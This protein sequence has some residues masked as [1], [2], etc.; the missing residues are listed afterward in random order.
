MLV[1][2]CWY[3]WLS[4]QPQWL[5][6]GWK[7]ASRPPGRLVDRQVFLRATFS[8]CVALGAESWDVAK[9]D[10]KPFTRVGNGSRRP[11]STE[12]YLIWPCHKEIRCGE[13]GPRRKNWAVSR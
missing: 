3:G 6:V 1:G 5:Q 8:T 11:A 4:R 13:G 9:F 12:N 2:G 10:M 7:I